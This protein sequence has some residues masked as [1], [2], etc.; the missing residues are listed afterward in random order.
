MNA[1]VTTLYRDVTCAAGAL[2]L[3]TVFGMAFIE[4]TAVP[5][6]ARVQTSTT[7]V[8]HSTTPSWFGQPQP[9]VLVD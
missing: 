8:A 7:V 9:A 4:S 2:L 3:T 1:F 5:P 6:G